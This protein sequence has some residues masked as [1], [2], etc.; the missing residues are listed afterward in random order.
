[1]ETHDT[2]WA[3]HPGEEKTFA[4]IS[5][6]FHQ[7]KMKDDVQ[8]YM[9]SC[10]VCQMDKIEQKNE[11]C[12]LY[13]LHIPERPW[14]CLS[15][16]FITRFPKVQGYRLVVLVVDQFSKYAVFIPA[17]HE[18]PIKEFARLFFSNA[19]KYFGILENIVSDRDSRFTGKFQVEL[20]KMMGI[21]CKFSTTNHPQMDGK[22]ERV[23][24]LLEEY[25]RHY[26]STTQQ[27]QLELMDVSQLS[28]N[29][30]QSSTIRKSPF[31]VAIR[32]QPCMLMDVLATSQ[33]GEGVS[34]AMYQSAKTRHE[35]LDEA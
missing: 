34:P 16:D 6:F 13:P 11:T 7:P 12:L 32:F 3:G 33:L 10:L 1:M 22:T 8:T 29:L 27:N 9:K 35:L 19:V 20:F 30:H 14:Q 24:V 18:C 23:N 4:L 28:Y 31:E 2:M 26:V 21:E 25:L 17:P 5:Q 15:M